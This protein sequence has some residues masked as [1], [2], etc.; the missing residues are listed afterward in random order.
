MVVR[1]KVD[2]ATTSAFTNT[3][4]VALAPLTDPVSSNNSATVTTTLSAALA[5]EASITTPVSCPGKT[6]GAI[7]ITV[8]G[9]TVPYNYSWTG[10]N[11]FSSTAEDISGLAAGDYELTVTDANEC[12]ETE[13]FTVG[14]TP[15]TE[16]PTFT[17]PGPFEFCVENVFSATY[18]Q[19]DPID[20][21]QINPDPDYYLFKAGNTRLDLDPAL[22]NFND[23]CCADNNLEIHW[24]IDF[25][26]TPNPSPPPAMLTHTSIS[27]TGQPSAYGADIQFPGDGVNFTSIIHKITYW[28]VDCNGNKSEERV[29]DITIKPR[30]QIIKN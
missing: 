24:R 16:P 17:A 10:P 9:G 30:P 3:A 5:V 8:T 27:G 18:V 1:G 6:D 14:T 26:D 4:T 29:A 15:D 25:T 21:V 23:N 22:Q 7:N 20:N 11:S 19:T 13:T 2:C 12:L 28:L